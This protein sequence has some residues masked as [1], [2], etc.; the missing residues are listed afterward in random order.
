M[1]GCSMLHEDL[2]SIAYFSDCWYDGTGWSN[3]LRLSFSSLSLIVCFMK[4]CVCKM[5]FDF[6]CSV[7]SISGAVGDWSLLAMLTSNSGY[8]LDGRR[9]KILEV[10]DAMRCVV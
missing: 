4:V 3:F 6:V 7:F 9:G 1:T 10:P 8:K 2:L 5:L